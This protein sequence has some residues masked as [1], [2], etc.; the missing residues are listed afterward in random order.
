MTECDEIFYTNDVMDD[1]KYLVIGPK[2][3]TDLSGIT[4]FTSTD[5]ALGTPL[6]TGELPKILGYNVIVT[7]LLD[8]T[9]NIRTCF[10]FSRGALALGIG[11]D[12]Q[13]RLEEYQSKN[14]NWHVFARMFIGATRLHEER[15]VKIECVES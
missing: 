13:T 5:Y 8:L 14:Y 3:L 10:A 9:G 12:I 2:Q 15:V 6:G 4:E 7:N 1:E 11:E